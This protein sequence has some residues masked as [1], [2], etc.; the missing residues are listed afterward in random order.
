MIDILDVLIGGLL[1][2]TGVVIGGAIASVR[3]DRETKDKS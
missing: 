1:G 3:V 2:L